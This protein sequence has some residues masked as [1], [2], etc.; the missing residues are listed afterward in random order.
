MKNT[1]NSQHYFES[2]QWL[3]IPP[4]ASEITFHVFFFSMILLKRTGHI[5]NN[6]LALLFGDKS[7]L[8]SKIIARRPWKASSPVENDLFRHPTI[9]QTFYFSSHLISFPTQMPSA[10]FVAVC[11]SIR[12][13][14]KWRVFCLRASGVCTPVGGAVFSHVGL[15][16]VLPVWAAG[17]SSVPSGC[18]C[19]PDL[20]QKWSRL[21]C[22]AAL[23]GTSG[24]PWDETLLNGNRSSLLSN[25]QMVF[26]IFFW[27]G[28]FIPSSCWTNVQVVFLDKEWR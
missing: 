9:S 22:W 19:P 23:S 8:L 6:G 10:R 24:S 12:P 5:I 3:I 28:F 7:S 1:L 18:V 4:S 15:R 21:P 17:T 25:T 11:S 16:A 20:R 13:I 2:F 26:K 27:G 14:Q